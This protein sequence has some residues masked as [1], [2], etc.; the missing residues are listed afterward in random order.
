MKIIYDNLVEFSKIRIRCEQ[1]RKE[2]MCSCCPFY[3]NCQIDD[4]VN[5]HIMHCEISKDTNSSN[6]NNSEVDTDSY[7]KNPEYV[8]DNWLNE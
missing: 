3:D 7:P 5:L 8:G 6:T 4:E 1:T 2:A